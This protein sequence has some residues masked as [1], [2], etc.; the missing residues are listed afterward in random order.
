MI[1]ATTAQQ[2][3][4]GVF[5]LTVRLTDPDAKTIMVLAPNISM[6]VYGKSYPLNDMTPTVVP[7]VYLVNLQDA[8]VRGLDK[9]T[10]LSFN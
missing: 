10:S 6:T 5:Q 9:D 4:S 8:L 7:G 2:I 1:Y 3:S